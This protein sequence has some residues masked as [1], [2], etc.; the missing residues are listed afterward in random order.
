MKYFLILV[1][2]LVMAFSIKSFFAADKTDAVK[3]ENTDI[4]YQSGFSDI[5]NI[6][7]SYMTTKRLHPAP[8][9]DVPVQPI[10]ATSLSFSNED[11]LFRL[12]HSTIL[13]RLDGDYILLDPVFSQRASPV[14]WAGP[15]RF[16]QSPISIE[17]LPPIKAVIISHDH[18]DH[19]DKSAITELSDK[20]EHFVTPEKVGD[21]L[22]EWGVEP[23]KV[24]Q[25][26]WWQELTIGELTLAATPAQHFSGRG[27]RDRDTTLWASWV[28]KGTNSNLFF[29]GDGGYFSGFKEIGERYGPF[30]ITM[31]ETG[32][33]NEMWSQIHMMPEQSL[34][35]HI[36]LNGSEFESSVLMPIHNGT[37]D[38][39]LHDWF[40]PLEWISDLGEQANVS[41]ITP[42]FGEPV[43]VASPQKTQAWWREMLSNDEWIL[44]SQ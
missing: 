8:V 17:Q 23:S 9:V 30:D 21:Y 35:A 18:Y 4:Q 26:S 2:V 37:F 20:V 40:E 15:K 28:I 5:W 13:I 38:L 3:F 22:I 25:L 6:A 11:Q 14:Q 39:A 42:V 31:I 44:Q 27:L 7:K 16:H 34:Q 24:S 33:Y 43:N 36:D 10:T 41:V 29:S 19:L 1:G 12:G 32:A